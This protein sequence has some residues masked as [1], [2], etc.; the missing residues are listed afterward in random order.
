MRVVLAPN[1]FK[2][3]FDAVEVADAWADALSDAGVT[4]DALPLSDGGDGFVAVVGRHRPGAL[5]VSTR[6]RDP[7]G[8]P[9]S[10]LWA[11]DPEEDVAYVESAAAVGLRLLDEAE[12]DPPSAD[13]FGLG[14]LLLAAAGLDARRIVVG[15]GGS[16]TVDGGWGMAR[17]LGFGFVREDGGPVESPGELRRLARIVPPK[18]PRLSDAI[19]VVALADVRSPLLGP[20]GAAP[21]YGPQKGADADVVERLASGLSRLAE[22]WEADL[23]ASEDLAERPGAGAAGGLGAALVAVAGARLEYGPA[24]CGRLAG[25]A[26]ALEEAGGLVT[27]EGRFDAQS[28]GDKATG[29]ALELAREAGVPAAVV[30]GE[31]ERAPEGVVVLDGSALDPPAR[32]PLDREALGRLARRAV[33]RLEAIG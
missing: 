14:Q 15:L 9:V 27:G 4:V 31:A 29:H 17:A 25:L 7:R 23:G 28:A 18:T 33:A 21:V 32:G 6:I 1:A 26:E 13:S 20:R 5:A 8:R 19:E 30:C 24:W 16:A 3:T 10:A 11:W 12:R 22:R 2:G